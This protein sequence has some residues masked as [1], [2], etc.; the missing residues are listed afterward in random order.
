MGWGLHLSPTVGRW[1][2]AC[3]D[4][5]IAAIAVN[6]EG[7]PAEPADAAVEVEMVLV[8]AVVVGPQHDAE[9]AA[10]AGVR[11]AQEARFGPL[12]APLAAHADVPAVGQG[13]AADVDGVGGGVL[14]APAL[15]ELGADDIAAGVGAEALHRHDTL[16]EV[17]LGD[18]LQIV[19]QPERQRRRG[20]AGDLVEARPHAAR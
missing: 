13:E 9:I 16:A 11:G 15:P 20:L 12:A 7:L 8:L 10:G 17:L 2:H 1:W 18:L 19:L 6:A 3:A 4:P 14:A 5:G